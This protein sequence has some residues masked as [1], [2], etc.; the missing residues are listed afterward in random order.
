MNE[1]IP[2][3]PSYDEPS[4]DAAFATLAAEVRDEALQALAAYG[5]EA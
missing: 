2:Q 3:L 1:E 5:V 4:L